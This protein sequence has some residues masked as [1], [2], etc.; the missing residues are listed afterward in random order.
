MEA[1]FCLPSFGAQPAA[2]VHDKCMPPPHSPQPRHLA[3]LASMHAFSVAPSKP[4]VFLGGFAMIVRQY[5]I[6][7][8]LWLR[9]HF[10]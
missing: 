10:C 1:V 3:E 7:K 2:W 6:R 5:R 9:K 4:L 8:A